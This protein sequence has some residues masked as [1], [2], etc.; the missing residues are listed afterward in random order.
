VKGLLRWVATVPLRGF[1]FE[2]LRIMWKAVVRTPVWLLGFRRSRRGPSVMCEGAPKAEFGPNHG[3]GSYDCKVKEG[4][5]GLGNTATRADLVLPEI[6]LRLGKGNTNFRPE[7]DD[8]PPAKLANGRA[9]ADSA[10]NLCGLDSVIRH[11]RELILADLPN[12]LI[13]LVYLA[14]LRDCNTD[15]YFHPRISRQNDSTSASHALRLC[16]EEVFARLTATP[17]SEYVTQLGGYI[18][19]TH[20]DKARVIDTWKSLPAYR[21][22]V[23]LKA[24]ILD[25]EFF[26]ASVE[27]A[28]TVLDGQRLGNS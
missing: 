4:T 28:L 1:A 27:A 23:P 2:W 26:F 14:S 11:A 20:A 21:A 13:K 9:V 25:A 7:M 24:S 12:D 16:H 6:P 3:G 10:L 5:V 17:L 18:C 19:Y 15:H 8:I 22:T